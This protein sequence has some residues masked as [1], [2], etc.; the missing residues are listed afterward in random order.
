LRVQDLL[1]LS[2]DQRH[3]KHQHQPKSS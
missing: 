2:L 1:T 3:R